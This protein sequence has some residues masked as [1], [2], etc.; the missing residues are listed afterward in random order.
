MCVCL[1]LSLT[2]PSV[3][4][5]KNFVRGPLFQTYK[6]PWTLLV[7]VPT[8]EIFFKDFLENG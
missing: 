2:P 6:F 1:S 4:K 5:Y 7:F 8:C 3:Y